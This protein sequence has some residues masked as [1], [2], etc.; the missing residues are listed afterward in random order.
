MGKGVVL[1]D[2]NWGRRWNCGGFENAELRGIAF[3]RLPT[4]KS[5][6]DAPADLT[7]VQP[8]N[9]ASR[10]A[11][12]SYA[13]VVDPGE[14]VLSGFSIKVARS[15]SDVAYWVAKRSE[16]LEGGKI[17]GG[18]FKVSARETVYIGNFWLDCF[19]R[20]QLWRYYTE[21]VENFHTHLAQYKNKYPYID[22]EHVTYRL[23]DTDALGRPYTLN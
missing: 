17:V 7:L 14:Y 11:F 22:I 18:S 8:P 10:P 2:V 1:L 21:G 20:P 13:I 3:D 19:Q 6:D 16:L 12:D 23:F 9:L 4:S 5:S 15:V